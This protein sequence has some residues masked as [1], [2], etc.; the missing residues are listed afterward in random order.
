[1]TNQYQYEA[2]PIHPWYGPCDRFG[3]EQSCSE[4][5][6][7]VTQRD[8]RIREL[9]AENTQFR[10]VL[11]SVALPPYPDS[12]LASLLTTLRSQAQEVLKQSAKK[13]R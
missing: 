5:L 8:Q 11:E 7:V 12:N 4:C 13:E 1:M 6:D 3:P 10:A 2:H 9:V